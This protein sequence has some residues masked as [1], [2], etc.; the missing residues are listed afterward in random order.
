MLYCICSVCN[1]Y[2][3]SEGLWTV[4]WFYTITWLIFC[5][6]VFFVLWNMCLIIWWTNSL[7]RTLWAFEYQLI[8]PVRCICV[9]IFQMHFV[10]R[11]L[12]AGIITIFIWTLVLVAT[13]MPQFVPS[14]TVVISCA[15][16][17]IVM[18]TDIRFLFGVFAP[19]VQ[20]E[21]G[22]VWG[23]IPERKWWKVHE[24]FT[25]TA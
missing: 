4:L 21:S 12:N 25:K 7:K 8:K 20:F 24:K 11:W 1:R 9:L 18:C 2:Y 14:K 13:G 22:L 19:D 23:S 6:N 5:L 15:V 16:F 10:G 17:T 3:N